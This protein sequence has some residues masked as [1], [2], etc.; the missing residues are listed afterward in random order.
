MRVWECDCNSCTENL[1]KFWKKLSKRL[2]PLD[3]SAMKLS[4]VTFG[5]YLASCFPRF[6]KKLRPIL[7]L[8]SVVLLIPLIVK[9]ARVI[10]DML[11]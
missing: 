9:S 1:E 3:V 4:G 11:R 6:T 2:T 7:A 5:L 8:A 10:R